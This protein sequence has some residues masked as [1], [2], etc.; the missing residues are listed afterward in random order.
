MAR[1]DW[2]DIFTRPLSVTLLLVGIIGFAG[3]WLIALMRRG[4]TKPRPEVKGPPSAVPTE[5]SS[6]P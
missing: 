3:P 1:G 6:L 2:S 4:R 5:R